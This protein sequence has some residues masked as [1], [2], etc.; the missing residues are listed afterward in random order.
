MLT[1][2][3]EFRKEWKLVLWRHQL[4]SRQRILLVFPTLLTIIQE[5]KLN[6]TLD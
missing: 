5:A 1:L 2:K 3:Q 4:V 6:E